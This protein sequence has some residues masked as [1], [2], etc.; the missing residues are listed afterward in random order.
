MSSSSSII[1]PQTHGLEL[2]ADV[3]T[4][5]FISGF[6]DS[7]NSF[8]KVYP[9]FEATH[10]VIV[11]VMPDHD[12]KAGTRLMGHS[13]PSIVAA[14]AK[15]MEPAHEI[16]SPITLVG[17]DWGSYVSQRLT[18]AHPKLIHR[19]VILD[20][21]YGFQT[22]SL[23][24]VLAYQFYLAFAFLVSRIPLIGNFLGLIMLAIYPWKCIGPCPHEYNL[25]TKPTV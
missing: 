18:A 5:L 21:G 13:F 9:H 12:K 8:D 20:V 11:C 10:H 6:P 1:S 15:A 7:H 17:H 24:I 23:H 4:M 2:S 3:P 14:L 19:L 25:P 22:K 16:G